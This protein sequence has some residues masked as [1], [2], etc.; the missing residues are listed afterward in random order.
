VRAQNLP[1]VISDVIICACEAAGMIITMV[2][3][4][5][6][7]LLLIPF[8]CVMNYK[9]AQLYR[10]SSREIKRLESIT[11]SFVHRYQ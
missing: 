4:S 7:L 6:L 5:P 2:V 9:L 10:H 11:N 1:D 3:A 8:M